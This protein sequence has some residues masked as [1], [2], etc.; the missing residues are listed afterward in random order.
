VHV[1]AAAVHTQSV[2]DAPGLY[3]TGFEFQPERRGRV[4]PE[5]AIHQLVAAIAPAGFHV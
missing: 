2:P 1:T 3:L 4:V 5:A